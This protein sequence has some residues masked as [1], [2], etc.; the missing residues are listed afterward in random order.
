MISRK[1]KESR[2]NSARKKMSVRNKKITLNEELNK[3]K[4]LAGIITESDAHIYAGI[5]MLLKVDD[6]TKNTLENYPMPEEPNG[7]IM[8]RLPSDKLHITLTSIANFKS[9]PNKEEFELSDIPIPA[10]KLGE[11]RFIYRGETKD[12]RRYLPGGK[13][14][15][16]VAVDNQDE[17][18]DYVNELYE[19][20]GLSNPEPNRFFHATIRNNA[21]GDPF[22]SIGNVDEQDFE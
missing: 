6:S 10:I 15:Y 9:V 2:E 4:T 17:L 21:G 5:G 19:S 22:Q 3:M 14:T 11:A 18:R 12:D 20:M 13:T 8:T 7:E 16:V 1:T